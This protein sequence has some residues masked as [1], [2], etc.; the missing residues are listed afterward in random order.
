MVGGGLG[1]NR[2]T[3]DNLI[4]AVS[5]GLGIAFLYWV[6]HSFCLSLGYGEMLPPLV[7]A[8]AGN[9]VF[10]CIGALAMIGTD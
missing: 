7:A 2:R 4:P 1:L 6:F 9:L 5:V 10:G 3:H 8:W